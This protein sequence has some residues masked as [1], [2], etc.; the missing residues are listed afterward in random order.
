MK[1]LTL[2]IKQHW[3]D[4]I[5]SGEKTVEYREVTPNNC[6]KLIEI[7]DEGFIIEPDASVKDEEGMQKPA[8]PKKYDAIRFY[9]G[10]NKDRDSALVEVK[11]VDCYA[12]KDENGKFIYEGDPKGAD[13]WVYTMVK[14][15][16]GKIIEKKHNHRA[17][18]LNG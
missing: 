18:S 11:D 1:T 4:K 6:K 5:M 7:D 15:Y 17:A 8:I 9:V 12:I 14:Y 3:F 16:L 13:F 10:Y 2:I